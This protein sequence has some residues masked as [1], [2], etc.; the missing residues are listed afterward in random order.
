VIGGG[1]MRLWGT[2]RA[3]RWRLNL[4]FD[5]MIGVRRITKIG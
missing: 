2:K 4:P 3:R 5:E 1:W